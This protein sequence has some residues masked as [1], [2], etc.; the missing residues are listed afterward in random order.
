MLKEKSKVPKEY[1]EQLERRR[2]SPNTIQ[3]YLS[4]FE[5]F[6]SHFNSIEPEQLNDSHV[7]EFQ[8]YLVSEKKVSTSSQ[9]QYINAI[10]FYFEKVLGRERGYYHIERPIK[11]F[12]L[13]KVLTEKEVSAILNSVHNLKHKAMLLMVYSSGLRAGELIKLHIGDID[14]EQM[15]VFVRGGKG[16]KDRVTIL[17]QKALVVLR[18]YFK[19]YRPKEYLFEGQNGGQYSDSSLRRVFISA[20]Q[21][22][23]LSKRVTLHSLRHSFATHLLEKG[24]DI[25]YIQVLLGHNSSQTT[26]IYTHITHKGWEKIQSP[27]DNLN[28]DD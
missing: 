15:R 25:R 3:T 22:A 5:K 8:T 7:A 17:S 2:Y 23:K 19:K 1:L 10:K 27:L 18:E 24:V 11:E 13:P 4:L 6:L 14:S 21:R 20:I 28:L 26:E 9:N 12:R 16:K